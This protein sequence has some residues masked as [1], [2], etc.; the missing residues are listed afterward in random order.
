M[1]ILSQFTEISQ[2]LKALQDQV[3][4][5]FEENDVYGVI[6]HFGIKYIELT[7][8]KNR[9]LV[10][11]NLCNYAI[12]TPI[13]SFTANR[14]AVLNLDRHVLISTWLV[15]A[16]TIVERANESKA[17]QFLKAYPENTHELLFLV[18]SNYSKLSKAGKTDTD[19]AK[20]AAKG[21][22]KLLEQKFELKTN[23]QPTTE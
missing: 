17:K 18:I 8:T 20:L 15:E 3:F 2:I 10:S 16:K 23:G 1:D 6:N 22:T 4:D 11:V 14:A 5:L 21:M 19:I 7:T 12:T 13:I 9:E